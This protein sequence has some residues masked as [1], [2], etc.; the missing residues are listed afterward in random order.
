MKRALVTGV[1][2]QVGSYLA[3]LLLEEGYEVHGLVRKSSTFAT[4][5]IDHIFE[6]L[7]L[8]YWDMGHLDSLIGVLN[9]TEPDEIY[10]LA[11]MSHVGVSFRMPSAAAMHTGVATT[12]LLEAARIVCPAAKFY[13]ASSSEIFGGMP[14]PQDEKTPIAP[15]SPYAAAKAYAYWMTKI[16]REA[17]GMFAV[18]GILFNTESPRRSPTFVTR[19]ITHG[20]ARIQAGLDGVLRLGNLGARRDWGHAQDYVRGIHAMMQYQEPRDWVLA[21]GESFSVADFLAT[22]LEVAYP[23]ADATAHAKWQRVHVQSDPNMLRP[24]EV[25]HLRGNATLART[26]LKWEPTYTFSSLVREMMESDIEC[27]GQLANACR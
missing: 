26:L 27:V 21:T 25:N 7:N 10:N 3:E 16:Y 19:K 23:H 22:A 14:P 2:G 13:Q 6:R 24:L 9:A 20:V 18:N 5:R 17:Y 4:E 15:R 12:S 1:T 8:H 11:A